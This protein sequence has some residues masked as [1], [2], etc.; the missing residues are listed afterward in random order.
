MSTAVR[1][2]IALALVL[3]PIVGAIGLRV[4]GHDVHASVV[5]MG[6]PPAQVALLMGPRTQAV[7]VTLQEMETIDQHWFAFEGRDVPELQQIAKSMASGASAL[8]ARSVVCMSTRAHVDLEQ[9]HA[10]E[11][12]VCVGEG[13]STDDQDVLRCTDADWASPKNGQLVLLTVVGQDSWLDRGELVQ[14]C[15]VSAE[16][17]REW[18]QRR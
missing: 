15:Q 4:G 12:Q 1:Y 8:G 6:T 7:E 10:N 13:S 2:V 11:I 17:W 18:H 3:T 14:S 16:H 5:R 9:A